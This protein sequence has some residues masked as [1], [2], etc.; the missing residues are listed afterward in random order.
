[1]KDLGKNQIALLGEH[2]SD[3]R[4]YFVRNIVNI[5]GESKTDQAIAFLRKAA[6]HENVRIRQ[7]VIKG[8]LSIGGKKAAGVL[9]KFLRDKDADILATAI[10][11]FAE[12]PGIGAEES[13][14]LL[15][16]L[17]GRPLKK[18]EQDLTLEAIRVL[19]KI[20]GRD[21]AEF[22]KRYARIRWWKPRKLQ[23]NSTTPRSGRGKKSRGERAMA[24]E[25]KR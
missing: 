14:P 7:E 10:R 24:D 4:W 16:F 22:L 20:G 6:D 12:L 1:M 11:A 15:A 9:A 2:L 17:E 25:A 18:K 8:L 3:E 5:L 21:A 19:G 23:L 13:T